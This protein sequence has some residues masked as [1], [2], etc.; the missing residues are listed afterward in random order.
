MPHC[1]C[2]LCVLSPNLAGRS[3]NTPG[4]QGTPRTMSSYP[5]KRMVQLTAEQWAQI[6]IE[7]QRRQEAAGGLP[8]PRAA[9][10]RDI[11]SRGLSTL[12]SA[13]AA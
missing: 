12:P 4:V 9:V 3:C 1:G 2:A 11:V 6:E 5:D 7:R 10:L 8:I 13:T